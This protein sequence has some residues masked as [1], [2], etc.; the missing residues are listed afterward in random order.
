MDIT[1]VHDWV[2]DTFVALGDRLEC[3]IPQLAKTCLPES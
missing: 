2:G 1:E 3:E